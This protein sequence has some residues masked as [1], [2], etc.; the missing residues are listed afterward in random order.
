MKP[1]DWL[2]V[3]FGHNDMKNHAPDAL[4]VYR[5]NLKK[6]VA[7]TRSKSGVPVLITSMERKGGVAGPTLAGYPDAPATCN[8]PSSAATSAAKPDGN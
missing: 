6:L 1:G 7:Q 3:Q 4:Q 2:L 8:V 5:A